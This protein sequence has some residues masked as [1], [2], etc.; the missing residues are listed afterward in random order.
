MRLKGKGSIVTGGGRGIGKAIATKFLEEG[1]RVLIC[2]LVEDRARATVEELRPLGEIGWVAGDVTDPA[3]CK[4]LVKEASRRLGNL[5]V[6]VNNAG[7]VR[8]SPFLEYSEED[9]DFVL[10]TNLKS[11]FLMGQRFARFLVEKG[12]AGSIVNIASTNGHLAERDLAAYN[13]SKAGVILLSKTMAIELATR[14]IRVNCVS[15]GFILTELAQEAGGS[16][17]FV[18]NYGSK[19]PMARY[20]K[21]REVA[22][23][24]AFLASEEAS[25]VTGASFVVDGGQTSEE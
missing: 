22:D 19:I 25:F 2:D 23:V 14:E 5:N 15:P 6:L 8:F 7:T 10:K 1:S 13:A 9:W 16:H 21:P 12:I 18:A 11:V 3:F 24:V 20:G 17:D 4:E